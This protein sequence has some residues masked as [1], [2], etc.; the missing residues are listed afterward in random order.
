MSLQRKLDALRDHL[1]VRTR[2]EALVAM[3]RVVEDAVSSD[4]ASKAL[5]AA[6]RAPAF[7]L[8][9]EQDKPVSLADRLNDGPVMLAF[10]RG[11]WCPRCTQELA[12]LHA[13]AS[14]LELLGASV[15]AVSPQMSVHNR[16]CVR[17]HK[18][19]FPILHDAGGHVAAQFG[20]NWD[21][22]ANLRRL[23]L[24]LNVDLTKFN[25]DGRWALPLPARY[26]IDQG[27][28]IVYSEINASES[29]RMSPAGLL[30]A[31][32]SLQRNTRTH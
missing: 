21:V 29:H 26:L 17:K 32:K 6:S 2:S 19:N 15:L 11:D 13:V 28:A 7:T 27:Q 24:G 30:T 22:P 5:Q 12:A 9:D 23:Y 25:G 3:L 20:V 8:P 18:L 31:L 16:R 4:R 10:Y 14:Q 1:Q